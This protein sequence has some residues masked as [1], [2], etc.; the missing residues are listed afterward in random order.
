MLMQRSP[1]PLRSAAQ[2]YERHAGSWNSDT[3][4]QVTAAT[5]AI[6]LRLLMEDF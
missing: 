1:E 5:G 4:I 6:L 3:V 2:E